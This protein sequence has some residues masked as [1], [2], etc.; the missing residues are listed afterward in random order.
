M[1]ESKKKLA[2]SFSDLKVAMEKGKG[3]PLQIFSIFEQGC[4]DFVRE[5]DKLP[6]ENSKSFLALVGRMKEA[7]E[8]GKREEIF[9]TMEEMKKMKK[10]CHDAY[11]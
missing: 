5:T 1:L 8:R 4:R 3:D 9:E 7:M 11:K 6:P 2:Q 10:T